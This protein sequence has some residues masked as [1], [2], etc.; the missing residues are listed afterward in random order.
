MKTAARGN[1]P[2]EAGWAL[3]NQPLTHKEKLDA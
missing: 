1:D 2:G 3:N